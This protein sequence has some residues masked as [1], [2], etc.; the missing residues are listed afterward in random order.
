MQRLYSIEHLSNFTTFQSLPQVILLLTLVK[1]A[2][3]HQVT[4]MLATSKIVLFPGHNHLLATIA[5]GPSLSGAHVI[6]KVS[7]HR[8]RWLA[9][10]YDLETVHF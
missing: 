10:G 8:H 3:I 4:T 1:K 7:G 6:I 5:D 2:I 9:G